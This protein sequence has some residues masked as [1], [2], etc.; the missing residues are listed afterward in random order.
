MDHHIMLCLQ[1]FMIINDISPF[2]QGWSYEI[3]PIKTLYVWLST[4]PCWHLGNKKAA[5][6]PRSVFDLPPIKVGVPYAHLKHH[7]NQ[8]MFSSRQDDWNVVVANKLHSV[9]PVLEDGS[10]LIG[11]AGRMKLSCVVPTSVSHI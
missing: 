5:S 10:L 3:L 11:R 4:Q 7:F 8:Y 2:C 1:Q 6:A 9:K